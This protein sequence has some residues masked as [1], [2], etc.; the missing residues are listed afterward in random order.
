M[1]KL[2]FRI[3]YNIDDNVWVA[4]KGDITVIFHEDEQGL[5]YIDLQDNEQGIAFVQTVRA[6]FEGYTKQDVK[7]AI[8][9]H[10]APTMLYC[11]SEQDMEYLV[12]SKELDNCPATPYA[13]RNANVIF[14]GPD[15]AGVGGGQF[16]ERL[17][18]SLRT[19]LL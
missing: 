4:T 3:S 17:S 2:G 19:I 14:G 1:K 8:A 9:T 6:S 11:L 18:A 7:K 15:I 13:L 16:I 12:S 10:D 5:H